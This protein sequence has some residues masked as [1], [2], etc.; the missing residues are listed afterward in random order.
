[1]GIHLVISNLQY[2]GSARELITFTP[3]LSGTN[4]FRGATPWG[5]EACELV[6]DR[7]TPTPAP[8]ASILRGEV[9]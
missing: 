1:M 9:G 3:M 7:P 4:P 6:L 5:V 2:A 8:S